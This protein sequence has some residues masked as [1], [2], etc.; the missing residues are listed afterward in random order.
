MSHAFSSLH[1]HRVVHSF[2]CRIDKNIKSYL[3]I[4]SSVVLTSVVSVWTIRYLNLPV[5][6][7]RLCANFL[8]YTISVLWARSCYR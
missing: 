3:D 7:P 6:K 1:L 4:I 8:C 2:G 5:Y